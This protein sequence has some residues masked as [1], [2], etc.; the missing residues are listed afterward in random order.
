KVIGPQQ[1][2]YAD[3]RGNRQFISVGNLQTN[4]RIALFLVDYPQRTRLKMWGRATV[5][6]ADENPELMR[7]LIVANYR[8]VPERAVMIR[9]EAWAWNCSQH[10]TPRFT[11]AEIKA[12]IANK[13]TP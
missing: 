11:E 3:F 1:I 6:A 8:A 10:I 13:E 4:D 5:I 2:G 12:A 9:V 7:K